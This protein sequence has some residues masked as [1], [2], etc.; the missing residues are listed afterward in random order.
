VGLTAE[1]RTNQE[2][3]TILIVDDASNTVRQALPANADVLSDFLTETGDLNTWSGGAI[4][5]NQT[6]PDAWGE[7]VIARASTGEVITMDPR[8][9]W[10]G[11]YNWF[12]SRGVDYD[13]GRVGY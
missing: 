13:T 10:E 1:W 12:R 3:D 8:L 7:L 5:A 9:F 2:S 11:I 4:A 6:R